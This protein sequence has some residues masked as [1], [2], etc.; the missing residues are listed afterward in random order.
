M[1]E[2]DRDDADSI[3]G[4]VRE[5]EVDVAESNEGEGDTLGREIEG[6]AGIVSVIGNPRSFMKL[7]TLVKSESLWN[8]N[9]IRR[10]YGGER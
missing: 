6:G 3:E 7:E 5:V 4:T 10:T 1:L 9:W 8:F 2:A